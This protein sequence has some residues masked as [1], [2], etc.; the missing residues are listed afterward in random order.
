MELL[1]RLDFQPLARFDVPVYTVDV[2]ECPVA[3]AEL[4]CRGEGPVPSVEVAIMLFLF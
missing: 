1:I 3:A 4:D 2:D